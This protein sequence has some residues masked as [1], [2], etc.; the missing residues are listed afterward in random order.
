MAEN[1]SWTACVTFA[2]LELWLMIHPCPISEAPLQQS[3]LRGR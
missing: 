3:C 1:T 2:F